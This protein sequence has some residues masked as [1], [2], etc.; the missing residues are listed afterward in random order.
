MPRPGTTRAAILAVLADGRPRTHRELVEA[1]GLSEAAVWNALARAWREGSV[2]RTERPIYEAVE[3]FRGRAGKTRTTR[4]YHLYLLAP[5]GE[6][7][8]R[9]DGREFVAF[10]ERYL[11]ARGGGKKSKAR[12]ILEFLRR[13]GDRA[14]YSKEVVEAL[15]AQGVRP[16]DVMSNVRRFERK[17]LVYVRGYRTE[18][19]QTPFAK[20]YLLTWLD[21]EKPRERALEEAIERTERKLAGEASTNPVIQ[22]IH[23]IRDSIV[24]ASKLREIVGMDYLVKKLGC[25]E[26]EA[27]LALERALQLYPDLREVRLFGFYR[28]FYH[29]SMG[30]E[31]LRAAVRM[32]ENYLRR[33]KGRANRV[34]HNWEACVEWF[35]D[36]FTYGARFWTQQHRSKMD[37][38]R[39]TLHLLRPV[40][41][42]RRTAEVDRVWEVPQGLLA[43]PITYVLECKWGLVRKRDLDDFINVLRW[44]KEFGVDTPEG[45]MV[46]QGVVGIFAGGAFDP[47][48]KVRL[49]DEEVDL[50]SYAARLNIQLLKEADFNGKLRERGCEVTVGKVCRLARNEEE[51]R[52]TLNRIWEEPE[53]AERVLEE[54]RERNKELFKFERMLEEVA[55]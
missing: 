15:K 28:Y 22:R 27:E 5:R 49:R 29:G 47:K 37:P 6:K 41:G 19:G 38:K 9:I 42:R 13:H 2:M 48:E 53:G 52:E 14:F 46:R 26:E 3:L 12:L 35:V 11:D 18:G 10:S 25:T 51:V 4:A 8:V 33:V 24:E 23:L 55:E 30:E 36:R 40:G 16:A 21:Q 54:L 34:G 44:S 43:K 17:G 7:R 45:R 1:T 20:G 50:P 31:E 32:K 39:I